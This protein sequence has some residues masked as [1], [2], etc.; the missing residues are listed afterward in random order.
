MKGK[1]LLALTISAVAAVAMCGAL[2]GCD[3]LQANGPIYNYKTGARP[4]RP[5]YEFTGNVTSTVVPDAENQ[6]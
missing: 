1:K 4:P 2:S 6:A 3:S 5:P